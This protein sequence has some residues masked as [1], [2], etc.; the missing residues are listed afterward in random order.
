MGARRTK[1][2]STTKGGKRGEPSVPGVRASSRAARKHRT[3]TTTKTRGPARPA[4]AIDA[5]AKDPCAYDYP[6]IGEYALIGDCHGAALVHRSGSIDW[7]CLRR[8]DGGA[9]FARILDANTGG[10]F[11]LQPRGLRRSSRRYREDTMILETTV[12]TGTGEA[13]IVDAFAMRRGGRHQPLKQLLRVVEGVRGTVTLDVLIRPRFDYG[14]LRPWLTENGRNVYVA[15]GGDDA[16]VMT[17]P[18]GLD[19]DEADASL[20][21]VMTIRAGDRA[22]FSITWRPAHEAR[23]ESLP[24][25]E[26][27]RRLAQSGRWWKRWSSRTVFEGEHAALVRRSALVLK[28]LTTA[29]TGAIVAAPT[30]SLPETIG[31]NRNWDYRYCWVRDSALTVAALCSIGHDE[32]AMRLRD[33]LMR[34]TAGHAD[35]MQIMYGCY[36]ERRL[37]EVVLPFQ[38]YRGSQPVRIGNAAALQRQADI[39]GELLNATSLWHGEG[40]PI[41]PSEW[42]FL[43][44]VVEAACVAWRKPDHGIWEMRGP[45]RHF[46]HSKVMCWVAIDRGIKMAVEQN[47]SADLDHWR[48]TRAAIRHAVE[49]RG[50]DRETQ[51]FVQSFGSKE[52]DA[53]LLLLPIVGFVRACDPRMV[54]TVRRIER[55]LMCDGLVQRYRPRSESD[56]LTPREGAFLMCSFWLVDV[57]SLQHRSAAARKLFNRLARLANDVGLYAEEYDP[58]AG[59]HLGNFPQAFTHISLINTAVN[60]ARAAHSRRP[61][62]V[63]A[64]RG[65]GSESSSACDE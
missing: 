59:A 29:P 34:A 25:R 14:S 28:T 21:G 53:S 16:V 56:G 54:N 52:P 24:A 22:R 51:S 37:P 27:D 26:F 18:G 50:I 35:D 40:N 38:G 9:V 23:P 3:A 12:V 2:G 47:L 44:S 1:R 19:V 41:S 48:E 63:P 31:G 11:V 39:F 30:T 46:V 4:R 20:R 62:G 6:P 7:A 60:L 65:D 57:L 32:E 13:R 15:I 10:T 8:F 49:T 43:S 45:Q 36:G 61:P 42:R 58:E 17:T 33:F 55:E 64:S 5:S